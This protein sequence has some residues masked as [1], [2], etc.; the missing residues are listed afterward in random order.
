MP[1]E[2]SWHEGACEEADD[3]NQPLLA[4]AVSD[5]AVGAWQPIKT[6]GI[7][8]ALSAI[9]PC[10]DGDGLI[11]RVYEPAGSPR[12]LRLRRYRRDGATRER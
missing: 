8:A 7:G 1:H 2:G 4:M 11:L 10:E 5:R 9:K 12:R 6:E 3:L